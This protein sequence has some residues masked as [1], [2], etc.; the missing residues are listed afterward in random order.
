MHTIQQIIENQNEFKENI[1]SFFLK[2]QSESKKILNDICSNDEYIIKQKN[3]LKNR[4]KKI[5]QIK[6]IEHLFFLNSRR[7]ENLYAWWDEYEKEA[8]ILKYDKR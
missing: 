3:K 1:V 4:Y 7:N 8:K 2:E 5:K 6:Y